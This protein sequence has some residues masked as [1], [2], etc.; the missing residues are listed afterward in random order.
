MKT[1]PTRYTTEKK[2]VIESGFVKH[3][4]SNAMVYQE[5]GNVKTYSNKT[6]AEKKVA[7]LVSAGHNCFVSM[8]WPFLIIQA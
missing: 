4:R 5:K 3:N 1:P 8:S 6:Q 2:T 7:E